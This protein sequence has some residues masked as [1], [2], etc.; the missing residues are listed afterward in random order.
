MKMNLKMKKILSK[1][2][3]A[4]DINLIQNM[5]ENIVCDTSLLE[6]HDCVVYDPNNEIDDL[7]LD[8][9]F[10][11]RINN[12]LTGFE[13]NCNEILINDYIDYNKD[14]ARSI[15]YHTLKSFGKLIKQKYPIKSFCVIMYEYKG[16][17]FLR[18]HVYRESEGLWIGE[19]F[20]EDENPVLYE[21]V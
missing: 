20:E 19:N 15:I 10:I 18:F 13:V 16:T 9:N 4:V 6:V 2:G 7:K 3:I 5:C 21:V 1:K 12:D 14:N 17:L 8:W 11:L